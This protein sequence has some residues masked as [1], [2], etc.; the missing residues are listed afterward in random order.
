MLNFDIL[1]KGPGIVS[2]A[3]F[4]YDFS[5][6]ISS[7][8][9]PLTDQILLPGCLY[10]LRYWAYFLRYWAICVLQLFVIQVMTSWVLKL[11]LYF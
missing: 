3:C 9:I 6:K 4:V 5:K 10:F 2:P 7:C 8:Y 1:D 11:T